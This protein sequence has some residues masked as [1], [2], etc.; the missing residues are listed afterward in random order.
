MPCRWT[1]TAGKPST[2]PAH[3]GRKCPGGRTLPHQNGN[4]G[5]SPRHAIPPESPYSRRNPADHRS[6]R[7]SLPRLPPASA[8]QW[9]PVPPHTV[10]P[11]RPQSGGPAEAATEMPSSSCPSLSGVPPRPR[12][13]RRQGDGAPAEEPEGPAC[14]ASG[15][16]PGPPHPRNT[17]SKRLRT[18]PPGNTPEGR[19]PPSSPVRPH[20]TAGSSGLPPRG[21]HGPRAGRRTPLKS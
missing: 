18:S 21:P 3:C 16:P 12:L 8:P 20:S 14:P 13:P 19:I 11:A 17:G 10:H 1:A 15:I 5:P 2:L 4:P 6:G 9:R 7:P